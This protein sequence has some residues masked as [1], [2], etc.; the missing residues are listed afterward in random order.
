[1][2]KHYLTP[3]V[4]LNLI[5]QCLIMFESITEKNR[6]KKSRTNRLII[7]TPAPD[8]ITS[9]RAMHRAIVSRATVIAFLKERT[10]TCDVRYVER[11]SLYRREFSE[12]HR[13]GATTAAR[14]RSLS[15]I[16]RKRQAEIG[17]WN[18]NDLKIS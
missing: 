7:D 2:T 5:L 1:M 3:D 12:S 17:M 4:C 10:E 13:G 16:S 8:D 15:L 11:I 9:G 18:I 14:R 6:R